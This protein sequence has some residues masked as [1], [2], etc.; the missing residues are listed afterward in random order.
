MFVLGFKSVEEL[1]PSP[2]L[3]VDSA[4]TSQLP[5][6]M[7]P[8]RQ[9][10]RYTSV[11]IKARLSGLRNAHPHS[12]HADPDRGIQHTGTC[13]LK[14]RIWI[15]GLKISYSKKTLWHLWFL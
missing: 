12:L 13:I 14:I 6:E 15:S 11:P 9:Y 1:Y 4:D 3:G 10:Y 2:P 7:N 8:A 5:K